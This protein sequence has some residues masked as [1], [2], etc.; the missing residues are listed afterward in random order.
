M[1]YKTKICVADVNKDMSNMSE[2]YEE[3]RMLMRSVAAYAEDSCPD[4]KPYKV[5]WQKVEEYYRKHGTKGF[6]DLD[7]HKAFLAKGLFS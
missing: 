6:H 3:K 7:D 4:G 1:I 2:Y 5:N